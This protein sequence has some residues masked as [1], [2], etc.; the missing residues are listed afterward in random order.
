MTLRVGFTRGSVR[1]V[2]PIFLSPFSA[3]SAFATFCAATSP[4]VVAAVV[5]QLVK[6]AQER[7]RR[8]ELEHRHDMRVQYLAAARQ[9]ALE[10]QKLMQ[11]CANEK[12]EQERQREDG[13]GL[14]IL[15]ARYGKNPTSPESREPRRDDLDVALRAMREQDLNRAIGDDE[16]IGSG[17]NISQQEEEAELLEQRWIDV[18][19]PL[20]FFVKVRQHLFYC[21]SVEG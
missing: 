18:T 3:Q 16:E 9:G 19:V 2:V 15:L 1:F 14:V 13:K 21:A 5:T 11:R 10:Q 8:L 12:V 4:F 7:K 20:R 17:D 6:P